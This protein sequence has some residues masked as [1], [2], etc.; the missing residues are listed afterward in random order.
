MKKHAFIDLSFLFE[1]KVGK[2]IACANS[3]IH[4]G[5]ILYNLEYELEIWL[6]FDRI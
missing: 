3:Y 5:F 4:P 1:L 6:W 2:I